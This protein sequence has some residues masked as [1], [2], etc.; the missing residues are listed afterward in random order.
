MDRKNLKKN[1]FYFLKFLNKDGDIFFSYY[2][3]LKS[4]EALSRYVRFEKPHFEVWSFEVLFVRNTVQ[5]VCK[6]IHN[7]LLNF[8]SK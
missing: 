7:P 8:N 3:F 6:N 2:D 5:M 1:I 4:F